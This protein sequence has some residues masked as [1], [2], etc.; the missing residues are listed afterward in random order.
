[1][2]KVIGE[3]SIS[4]Y[5]ITKR[6]GH[7]KNNERVNNIYSWIFQYPQVVQSPIK[8]DYL[9]LYIDGNTETQVVPKLLLQVSVWELHDIIVIQS[10]KGGLKEERD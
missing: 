3:G 2:R 1:M 6:K 4:W 7:T 8:N 10:E 5:S 9:K